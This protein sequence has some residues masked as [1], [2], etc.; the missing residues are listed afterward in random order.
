MG[1]TMHENLLLREATVQEIQLE[2][3]RR[4]RFNTF[5]GERICASLLKHRELWTAVLLD[6]PGVPNY[7][8]P[9]H[10]LMVG[11]IKLRDLPYNLWNADQLFILT[12]TRAAAQ[13]WARIAEEEDWL[14][15]VCVY[16]DQQEMDNALGTGRQEYGLLSIWWD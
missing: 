7:S 14:G 1:S 6:S 2:L 4:T 10:L 3:V 15:E 11:L 16:D 8:E 12:P 13:E 5:D 9:R